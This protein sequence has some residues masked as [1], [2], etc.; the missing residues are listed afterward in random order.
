VLGSV[1]ADGAYVLPKVAMTRTGR[2]GRA[3]KVGYRWQ[4][5]AGVF[6]WEAQ[7]NWADFKGDISGAGAFRNQSRVKCVRAL[8]RPGG[9]APTSC[10]LRQGG[11]AVTSDRS[12]S[13]AVGIPVEVAIAA[14]PPL[15][16]SGA[17]P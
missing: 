9:Y 17:R 6:G 12:A 14:I 3:V 15:G 2:H 13:A 1:T 8:H 5:S 10:V 11:A 7:G 4:C 16:R